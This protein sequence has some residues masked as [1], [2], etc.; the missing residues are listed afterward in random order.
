M[1]GSEAPAACQPASAN[2]ETITSPPLWR[3]CRNY[4]FVTLNLIQGLVTI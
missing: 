2:Y 4:Y 1:K 3:L